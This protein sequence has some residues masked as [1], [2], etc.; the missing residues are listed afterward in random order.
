MQTLPLDK[1]WNVCDTH[2][3]TPLSKAVRANNAAAL[4]VLLA[5]T[6]VDEASSNKKCNRSDPTTWSHLRYCAANGFVDV[7]ELL[8]EQG[9]NNGS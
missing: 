5:D 1:K 3:L 2:G 8:L 7:L 9:T 4:K 6:D